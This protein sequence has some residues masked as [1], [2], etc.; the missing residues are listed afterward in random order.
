M[1]TVCNLPDLPTS[2]RIPPDLPI[3]PNISPYLPPSRPRMTFAD[4][5][6]SSA[7][8]HS[9]PGALRRVHGMRSQRGSAGG[10]VRRAR[11]RAPRGIPT[12]PHLPLLPRG[13]Y[14]ALAGVLHVGNI[15][16]NG[17]EEAKIV[18]SRQ[19]SRKP[20][21]H[22][23]IAHRQ[24]SAVCAPHSHAL[25]LAVWGRSQLSLS[26]TRPRRWAPTWQSASPHAR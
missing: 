20:C 15:T 25:C 4:L 23:S 17:D 18:R 5:L 3:P 21:A 14:A 22:G 9:L 2:R 10:N 8:T 19:P 26:R 12:S 7:L 24:P 1:F 6:A 13:R 11:S 16:F